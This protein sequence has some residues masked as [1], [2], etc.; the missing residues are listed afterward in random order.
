MTE[1]NAPLEEPTE[2]IV[3]PTKAP[4]KSRKKTV[5]APEP[6][7]NTIVLRPIKKAY[8]ASIR[9]FRV[10][11]HLGKIEFRL[12]NGDSFFTDF[13]E[14]KPSLAEAK[15]EIQT[16]LHKEDQTTFQCIHTTTGYRERDLDIVIYYDDEKN[17]VFTQEYY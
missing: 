8:L 4:L 9:R 2:V 3:L 14:F 16:Y 6:V 5:T 1:Y 7:R 11:E 12:K 15:P 17:P 13:L 10:G